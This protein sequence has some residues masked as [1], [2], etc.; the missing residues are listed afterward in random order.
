MNKKYYYY[1]K[2]WLPNCDEEISEGF[3]HSTFVCEESPKEFL[4][5]I[6]K[7]EWINEYFVKQFE[8]REEM[9]NYWN[10]IHS[11]RQEN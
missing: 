3:Y 4:S 5:N 10:S 11:N 1:A 7:R 8:S 2:W 6:W 9:R